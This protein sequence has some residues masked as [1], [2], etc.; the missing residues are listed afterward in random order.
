MGS[1]STRLSETKNDSPSRP[2]SPRHNQSD[3]KG[4]ATDPDPR[5]VSC[6]EALWNQ[7]RVQ[8]LQD[9][10][11]TDQGEDETDHKSGNAHVAS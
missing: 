11:G 6:H 1:E 2:V 4:Q 3:C 9:P 7:F 5:S 8:A 10:D